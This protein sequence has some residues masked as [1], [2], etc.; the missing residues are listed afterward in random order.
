[1]CLFPAPLGPSTSVSTEVCACAFI[2]WL[3]LSDIPAAYS[4]RHPV[5]TSDMREKIN[6]MQC[7]M[8]ELRV[9]LQGLKRME[10]LNQEAMRDAFTETLARLKV[11][12]AAVLREVAP[13]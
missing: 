6:D 2:L 7:R 5:V 12:L 3:G 13:I 8:R 11:Y 4:L 1:M 10:Q 9:E